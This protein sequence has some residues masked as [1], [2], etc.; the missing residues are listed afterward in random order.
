MTQRQ[1]K[2]RTKSLNGLLYCTDEEFKTHQDISQMSPAG[3]EEMCEKYIT[4]LGWNVLKRTNYDGGI[5]IRAIKDAADNN[6]KKLFVQCK[7]YINSNNPIGPDVV[8]ELKGSVDLDE[9]DN[10]DCDIEMMI[11]SSTRYTFKAVEAAKKLNIKLI[12]TDDI[13]KE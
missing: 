4:R 1:I 10:K 8:R 9:I 3:F 11:I 5:D 6:I 13:R 2:Y 7:H 12:K